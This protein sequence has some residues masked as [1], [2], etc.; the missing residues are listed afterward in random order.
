[1]LLLSVVL[2]VS[3]AG[4]LLLATRSHDGSL[5]EHATIVAVLGRSCIDSGTGPSSVVR[6][7]EPFVKLLVQAGLGC[8]CTCLERGQLD[9]LRCRH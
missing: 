9:I 7:S 5:N 3:L 6:L 8:S 1:M 2:R 4:A